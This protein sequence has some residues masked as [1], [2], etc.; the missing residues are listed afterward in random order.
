MRVFRVV[1]RVVTGLYILS[2]VCLVLTVGAWRKMAGIATYGFLVMLAV[3]DLMSVIEW[4]WSS[5]GGD[6]P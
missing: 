6:Q 5:S 3:G 1:S 2:F 4:R